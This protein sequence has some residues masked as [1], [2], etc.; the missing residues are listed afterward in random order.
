VIN[1]RFHLASLI[2]IFLALALGVVVGAGVIDRGVVDTLNNRLDSVE[3]RSDRIKGQNKALRD[4]NRELADAIRAEQCHAVQDRLV[5]DSIA[6]VAVRGVSEDS[7]KQT[8]AG[9][10]CAGA[11]VDGVL[12]LEGKWALANSDDVKAMAG[13]LGSTSRR[14]ATVRTTAWRRLA[15]RLQT[16]PAVADGSSDLL[17]ALADAGFVSFESTNGGAATISQFSAL[18]GPMML[19]VGADG[20]LSGPDIVIAGATAITNAGISLVVC[21]V[22]AAAG[23][24]P[25]RGAS[26][27]ALRQG[28]LAKTVSTVDNLDRPQGPATAVLALVGLLTVPPSVG[29][30]GLTGDKLLPDAVP[31]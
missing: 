23:G 25:S 14:S 13:V 9:A 4:E 17:G 20:D 5:G 12:W 11:T 1:F 16:S 7:V 26:L 15:E 10:G 3:R 22:Y 24:T 29:H 21:D 27:G 6:I 28:T 31:R 19:V 2:A 30:Y 18:G 8:I